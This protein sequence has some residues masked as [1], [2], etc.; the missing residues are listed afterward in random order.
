MGWLKYVCVGVDVHG[1]NTFNTRD[2]YLHV[3]QYECYPLMMNVFT[4]P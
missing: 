1:N 2:I 4:L 3:L